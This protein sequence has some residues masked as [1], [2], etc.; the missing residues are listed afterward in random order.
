MELS[1]RSSAISMVHK[2]RRNGLPFWRR[3]DDTASAGNDNDLVVVAFETYRQLSRVT[4]RPMTAISDLQNIHEDIIASA[5]Q[6]RTALIILPFHKFQRSDSGELESLGSSH[7]HVN[8]RVLRSA[9]CS[10]ALLIDRGL[11]GTGLI[12]SSDIAYSMAVLFFGGPDD[13]EALEY[14]SRLAEH[15]GIAMVVLRF[16]T[17][18]SADAD[19]EVALERFKSKSGLKYEEVVCGGPEDVTAAVKATGRINLFLVG[20]RAKTVAIVEREE[21]PELG[22]VGSY[23]VS[24]EFSTASVLVI[25]KYDMKGEPEITIVE[26]GTEAQIYDVPDTPLADVLP[27]VSRRQHKLDVA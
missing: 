6:K 27:E 12:S 23:L 5:Q 19:D 10:V 8:Q 1:E 9:P 16:L 22:P 24:P 15:P 21:F 3:S 4:I 26:E 14:G 11:G 17:D 25:Q 20:R 18:D 7:R 13:R 2:A